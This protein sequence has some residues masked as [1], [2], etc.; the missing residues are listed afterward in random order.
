MFC[1]HRAVCSWLVHLAR[2]RPSSF[3]G[4]HSESADDLLLFCKVKMACR[5]VDLLNMSDGQLFLVT[6]RMDLL[7][8]ALKTIEVLL[9]TEA[10][11]V[12]L[13]TENSYFF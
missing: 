6:T 3:V 9:L 12:A 7:N 10:I 5:G 11:V 8:F 2:Q 13:K 4:N 1:A